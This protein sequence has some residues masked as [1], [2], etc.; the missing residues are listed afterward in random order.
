LIIST[1]PNLIINSVGFTNIEKCE[2]NK[3][4]SKKI[5]FGIVK[6]LFDLKKEKKLNFNLI[7]ISTDQFYKQKKNKNSHENS[8][9]FLMNTYCKHKRMAEILCLK[10]KALIF[11]TNFFGKTFSRNNSFSDW[12]FQSFRSKKK[13]YLFSDVL[14]NPLRINTIAKLISI[15]IRQK[16]YKYS[17]IYNLGTK[18]P[19]LKSEFAILFAKKTFIINNNYTFINVNKVLRVKRSTNMYM[20]VNKFEKIFEFKLPYIKTEIIKESKNYI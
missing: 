20:N 16:K 1:C 19:I 5:N 8:K 10:N 14:F 4:I 3:I 9:I 15:I 12:I 2:K 7:Q 11:R 18:D 17:G 13:L 6:E